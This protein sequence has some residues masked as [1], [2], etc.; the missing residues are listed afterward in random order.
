MTCSCF[1]VLYIFDHN[2]QL[3]SEEGIQYGLYPENLFY[4][5]QESL[6]RLFKTAEFAEITEHAEEKLKFSYFIKFDPLKNLTNQFII[7]ALSASSAASAVF[8]IQKSYV[9]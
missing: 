5:Y 3:A 2:Y 7:S 4:S 6:Y 9:G 1:F 8:P